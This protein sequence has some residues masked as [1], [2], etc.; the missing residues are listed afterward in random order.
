MKHRGALKSALN[1]MVVRNMGSSDLRWYAPGFVITGKHYLL[2]LNHNFK[3]NVWYFNL[4]SGIVI[5]I[6]M[7]N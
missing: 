1:T 3:E 4:K 7:F 2:I 6:D 5:M